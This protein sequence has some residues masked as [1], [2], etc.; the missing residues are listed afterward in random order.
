MYDEDEF[1]AL[2]GIQHFSFCRRQWALIHIE[3]AWADNVLT[4]EGELMHKRAHDEELRERRGDNLVVRG[5]AVHSRALG[6]SGKCDVVEFRKGSDGHPLAGEDG[7]WRAVPVEYKHGSGK[8][9]DADLLQLCAQALCLE[10][11]LGADV[12]TGFLYYGETRSRERVE[13]DGSLRASVASMAEE[14]HALYRRR[15]TPR[16]KP[17]SACRSC[18]LC[19]LCLPRAINR[20]TVADYVAK[21][22]SEE[23]L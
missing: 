6:L 18:S 12:P 2:S 4:A 21:R 5:L 11:M 7:L 8:A 19:D 9:N 20:T 14:M 22:L 1:L 23:A 13:L 16:V 15:H 3:Q 17:F 10:E